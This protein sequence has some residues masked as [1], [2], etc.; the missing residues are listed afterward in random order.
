MGGRSLRDVVALLLKH[1]ADASIVK[2]EVWYFRCC[3]PWKWC[4]RNWYQGKTAL[5][6]A[7]YKVNKEIQDLGDKELDPEHRYMQILALL[8]NPPKLNDSDDGGRAHVVMQSDSIG[9]QADDEVELITSNT[10]IVGDEEDAMAMDMAM[11]DDA[12]A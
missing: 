1:G 11:D 7:K 6:I 3:M 12:E 9:L 2:E 4:G 8:E 5:E 10:E